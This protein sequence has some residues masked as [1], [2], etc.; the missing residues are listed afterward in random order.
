MDI[1]QVPI[2]LRTH[3][4]KFYFVDISDIHIGYKYVQYD[5]LEQVI[6]WIKRK[7]NAYWIGIGDYMEC[8][9]PKDRRYDTNLIDW[10][11]HTPRKQK[12]H[13]IELFHP[14]RHKCLGL[15]KGNHEQKLWEMHGDNDYVNAMADDLSDDKHTVKCF[16]MMGA[17][18]FVFL[19]ENGSGAYRTV[20]QLVHHGFTG[21][22]SQ[23]GKV[24]RLLELEN[25]VQG[26][27]LYKMAHTHSL[28]VPLSE[29]RF[30]LARSS[31]SGRFE[32]LDYFVHFGLTGSF[33]EG[34]PISDLTYV[35]QKHYPPAIPGSLCTVI[36][37]F[38]SVKQRIA[39]VALQTDM[40][41]INFMKLPWDI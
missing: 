36:Q 14:I 37:P 15:G 29:R 21:S 6:D 26:C 38:K 2:K 18:V 35:E 41:G 19:R 32:L 11:L 5:L 7:R 13:F 1:I 12:D 34:Y 33:L 3:R 28:G 27:Q 16:D 17:F 40:V 9:T 24:N 30:K 22:R 23:G 31:A 20:K 10:G 25:I 39:G 8:I 4:E